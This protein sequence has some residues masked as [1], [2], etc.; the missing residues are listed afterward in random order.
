MIAVYLFFVFISVCSS[1]FFLRIAIYV[2]GRI[3][4]DIK[5]GDKHAYIENYIYIYTH[6]NS[7]VA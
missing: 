4:F 7:T 3:R 5:L 1:L 2:E 6:N